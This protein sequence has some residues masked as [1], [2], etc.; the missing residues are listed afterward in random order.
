MKNFIYLNKKTFEF[1]Y[2]KE[3]KTLISLDDIICMEENIQN[4]MT[5]TEINF[6]NGESA[7]VKESIKEIMDLF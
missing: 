2:E 4:D 3:L 5:F 6:E 1:Y 7:F